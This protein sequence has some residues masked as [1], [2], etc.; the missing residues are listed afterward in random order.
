M[1]DL[2]KIRR[3]CPLPKLMHRVGL[4]AYV[5]TNCASPFRSDT[6]PSWGIYQKAG[7]WYWKDF[8]TGEHGDEIALLAKIFTANE[9]RDFMELLKIYE[10]FAGGA[11][12]MA[13]PVVDKQVGTHPDKIGFQAGT[14]GQLG[15]LSE[16]RGLSPTGM[17]WAQ[18]R[19]VLV[20]GTWHGMEVYGVCDSSKKVLEIRRLDGKLFP[21]AGRLPA[22]KAHAVAGSQKR[23]P[24]GIM[25]AKDYACIVLVEGGP[26]FLAAHDLILREQGLDEATVECVPVAMLTAGCWIAEEALPYFA[27]KIVRIFPH[28]DA[29][30][31]GLIA[32]ARWQKHLQLEAA[33]VEIFDVSVLHALSDGNISDL[34]DFVRLRTQ[35]LLAKHPGLETVI[36]GGKHA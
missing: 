34:N 13:S 16:L 35:E 21:A 17:V 4:G 8:A 7:R 3:R 2:S 6:H 12:V 18:K 20:F 31:I 32:A 5:K 10:L 28:H 24:V 33:S 1:R 36:P 22:R 11:Q 19:G 27:G 23:W 26:D 15:R 14:E 29:S 25:E 9:Q 30:G